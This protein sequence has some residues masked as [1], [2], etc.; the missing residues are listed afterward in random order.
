MME[1]YEGTLMDIKEGEI[2]KGQVLGV[3]KDDVIVDVGFK[4]EGIIPM[5][6]F[7]PPINVQVG[8]EIEVY[9]DAIENNDG[10]LVLSKQKAD[11]LRVWDNIKDY[12]DEGQTVTGKILRRIKGGMV[13][14]LF[15]VDA[16]LPGSQIALRQVPDFDAL[17]GT[18][19]R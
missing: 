4:S 10:Q 9:L 16:F 11:F 19:D 1:M 2:V 6:E 18:E 7:T 13:V 3:T 5:H 14:D 17:I 12:H 15:G 8:E